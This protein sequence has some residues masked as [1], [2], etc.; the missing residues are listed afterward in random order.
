MNSTQRKFL[1]EK[2]QEETKRKIEVLQKSKMEFPNA[3]NY[4]FKAILDGKLKLQS[5]EHILNVLKERALSAVEGRNWLSGDT[6]GF[7]KHRAIKFNNYEDIIVL[8]KDYEE[9]LNKVKKHNSK[10]SA[11]IE[12]LRV[13]L[14]TIE[15]RIQ[16]AS[17]SVLKRLINDIDDMGDIKLI[18]T[19][20]KTLSLGEGRK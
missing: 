10:I 8:P 7:E 20:V 2:I 6:M 1:I 5:E 15:M 18:D 3:S 17:D 13:Y 12:D 14:N 19:T 4:V 9:E 11:E 16:L